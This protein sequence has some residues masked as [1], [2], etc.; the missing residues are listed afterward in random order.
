MIDLV[1]VFLEVFL[2][3]L[4]SRVIYCPPSSELVLH[5]YKCPVFLSALGNTRHLREWG[6][7][8]EDGEIICHVECITL[9]FLTFFPVWGEQSVNHGWLCSE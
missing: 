7:I 4:H 1:C 5:V 9:S 6:T 2:T 3:A 8:S